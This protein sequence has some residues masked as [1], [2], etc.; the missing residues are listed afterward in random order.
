VR[1]KEFLKL[2]KNIKLKE[3]MSLKPQKQTKTLVGVYLNKDLRIELL[4]KCLYGLSMQDKPID[5]VFLHEG[6]ADDELETISEV[7]KKP[8]I[9]VFVDGEDEDGKETEKKIEYFDGT[10]V[11]HTIE[12][13]EI[14][15]FADIFNKT[16]QLAVDSGYDYFSVVEC[17]DEVSLKWYEI[18]EKYAEENDKVGIFLPLIKNMIAESFTSYINEFCWA[19]NMAESAGYYDYMLLSRFNC[20]HPLGA[21]YRVSSLVEESDNIEERD[22]LMY[23]MKGCLKITNYYEF[24]LRM[25]YNDIQVM[26]IP[27]VGYLLRHTATDTFTHKSSKIP[28]HLTQLKPENGGITQGEIQHW[29]QAALDDYVFFDDDLSRVELI[30]QTA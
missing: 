7:I 17:E 30:E 14:N 2:L 16:F 26:N 22:G 15:S 10:E 3:H 27:R 5:V 25:V 28:S 20:I 19:D 29:T 11:N 13:I 18:A 1:R 4:N 9:S 21:L 8:T 24:F 6:F 12:Q 23:P